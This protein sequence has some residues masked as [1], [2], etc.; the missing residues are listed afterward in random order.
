MPYFEL[1][2]AIIPHLFNL[3]FPNWALKYILTLSRSLYIF[4]LID[5]GI[6]FMFNFKSYFS[7]L[8]MHTNT[9][10]LRDSSGAVEKAVLFGASLPPTKCLV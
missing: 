10:M 1:V 5:Q 4:G 8:F 7:S 2:H 3:R 9:A 6:E